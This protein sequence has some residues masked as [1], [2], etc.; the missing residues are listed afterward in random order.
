VVHA[1]GSGGTAAGVALGCARHE[2]ARRAIAMAVCDDRATFERRIA[3]IVEEARGLLADLPRDAPYEV[4]DGARGPAYGVM[5]DE[6]KAFLVDVARATG[7]VLDPVY[8]GKAMFGLARA[9]QR[10]S[11]PLGS[12]VLF[13]HTGGLPGTLADPEALRAVL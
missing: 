9:V 8:T 6:Q 5:S 1:C 4:D 11:I 3:S 12:R 2:V 10:G 13:L 7:I